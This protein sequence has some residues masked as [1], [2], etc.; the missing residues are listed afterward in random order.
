MLRRLLAVEDSKTKKV[1]FIGFDIT[2]GDIEYDILASQGP[3]TTLRKV[4]STPTSSTMSGWNSVVECSRL[5]AG[6]SKPALV[7]GSCH[8][9]A[10]IS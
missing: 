2:G 3:N 6:H 5:L 1:Q 7:T 8:A 9:L 10:P 4:R